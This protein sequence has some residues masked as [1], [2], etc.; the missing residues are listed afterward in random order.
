MITIQK[1]ANHIN[2]T[3][4]GDCNLQISEV[5][6]LKNG[7]SGSISFLSQSK[8]NK[9]FEDS[10]VS[11]VIVGLSFNQ[12]PNGKTLI[13]VNNPSLGFAQTLELF[14][15]RST[16]KRVI[17]PKAHIEDNATIGENTSIGAGCYIGEN[18]VIGNNSTI[19]TNVTIYD[20]CII[21]NNVT[22]DS[23]TVIGADG[24]GWVTDKGKHH[25]IPQIG[26]V[27]IK[28]YVWIGANCCIDRGTFQDTTIGEHTKIDNLIQIAHNVKI[29]KGCLF[30]AQVG[31]AGSTVV[32]DF[33]TMAG[34][35]GVIGHISIGDKCVIASKSA[36]MKSIKPGSF[37]SGIPARNHLARRKQD[38]VISQLPNLLKRIRKLENKI[39][40]LEKE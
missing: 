2:G 22:I 38:V 14:D 11:A 29:G 5:G 40:T 15:N 24:F 34:Q 39:D 3:I 30:A 33:V 1:I 13:K 36:V 12:N 23:G 9:F 6:N 10:D 16:Q 20:H 35:V 18:T 21:G 28:D 4:V 25:K 31:I 37:V 17:H 32:G 27:V 7:K 8:Y 26:S 19:N